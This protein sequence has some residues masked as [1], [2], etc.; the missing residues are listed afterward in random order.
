MQGPH[1]WLPPQSRATRALCSTRKP[2]KTRARLLH[3]GPAHPLPSSP[4]PGPPHAAAA[5]A[6]GRTRS[7]PLLLSHT[8][9]LQQHRATPARWT[10]PAPA[11]A[12]LTWLTAL[13]TAI[14]LPDATACATAEAEAVAVPPARSR[15]GGRGGQGGE[16]DIIHQDESDVGLR[17]CGAMRLHPPLR[18]PHAPS[19]RLR[20]R[21]GGRHRRGWVEAAL[22]GGGG[23]RALIL[24]SV[25]KP[26]PP[27]SSQPSHTQGW[28]HGG[29][30]R[31]GGAAPA[32]PVAWVD[33]GGR[34]RRGAGGR[35]ARVRAGLHGERLPTPL[36]PRSAPMPCTTRGS[37]AA[38]TRPGPIGCTALEQE[39]AGRAGGRHRARASGGCTHLARTL[40]RPGAR[41][42]PAAACGVRMPSQLG[43]SGAW[44]GGPGSW[45]IAERAPC[46]RL[47]FC[48][49]RECDDGAGQWWSECRL[50]GAVRQAAARQADPSTGEAGLKQAGGPQPVVGTTGQGHAK[51]HTSMVAALQRLQEPVRIV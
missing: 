40:S 28:G 35:G 24:D 18:P 50:A 9:P 2:S 38:A 4:L 33:W 29:A 44:G 21:T 11:G 46:P 7:P 16:R 31:W 48:V 6:H 25:N 26:F 47:R 8:T 34:G 42:P 15:R 19:G 14:E 49:G 5:P 43:V 13:A 32:A 27:S 51:E 30:P 41:T 1:L 37:G 3:P 23:S 17:A 20:H 12:L 22:L 45:V 36:P 39:A 10:R